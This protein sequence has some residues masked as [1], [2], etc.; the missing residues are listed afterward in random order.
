MNGITHILRKLF[1][2]LLRFHYLKFSN[3]YD[4]FRKMLRFLH[5]RESTT[6]ILQHSF[7]I[8]Y[9]FFVLVEKLKNAPTA[10]FY[11][12]FVPLRFSIFQK[13]WFVVGSRTGALASHGP[14]E[15][16]PCFRDATLP[17][18][19]LEREMLTV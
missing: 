14:Q 11:S 7:R 4:P 8:S 2:M 3:L 6:N 15:V 9:H 18:H 13:N 5:M 17:Y 1:R 16:Q 19:R 12:Y 10:H